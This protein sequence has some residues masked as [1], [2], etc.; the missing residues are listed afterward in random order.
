MEQQLDFRYHF[1]RLQ[2][3][4]I[5]NDYVQTV[6]STSRSDVS[7]L[8]YFDNAVSWA[9]VTDI[10]EVTHLPVLQPLIALRHYSRRFYIRHS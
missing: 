2:L 5:V 4:N 8:A 7:R 10:D 6:I 9:V 3:K 1:R